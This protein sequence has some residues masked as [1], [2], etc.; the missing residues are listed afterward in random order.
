MSASKDPVWTVL[1]GLT[2]EAATPD[3]ASALVRAELAAKL[4]SDEQPWQTGSHHLLPR[5]EVGSV[6]RE[7]R[8][9]ESGAEAR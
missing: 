4:P 7:K 3:E 9:D 2:V 6:R 5:Y 1:V 8:L